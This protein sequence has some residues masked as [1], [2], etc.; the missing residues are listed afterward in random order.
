MKPLP[1]FFKTLPFCSVLFLIMVG[2]S[3]QIGGYPLL[4]SLYLIPIYYWIIFRPD[5]LPLWSLAGIG[6]FYDSLMGC[7]LGFSSLLLMFSSVIGIYVRPFLTSLYF[8]LIWGAF[9][10]FSFGYLF[11]YGLFLGF[12]F[13]LFISWVYGV[14]LYPGFA[15]ILSHLHFRIQ[16]YV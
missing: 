14:I 9:S 5:W 7:E 15:W 10:L 2:C 11:I 13:P 1:L 8:L 3:F 4:P 12:A 6:L 16:S